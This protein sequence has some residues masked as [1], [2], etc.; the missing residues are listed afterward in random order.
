MQ[1]VFSRLL[2]SSENKIEARVSCCVLFKPTK[3]G[4]GSAAALM[5]LSLFSVKSLKA[6]KLKNTSPVLPCLTG[7]SLSS[8]EINKHKVAEM[9]M[10]KGKSRIPRRKTLAD[11]SNMPQGF[12]ASYQFHKSGPS[13]DALRKHLKQLQKKMQHL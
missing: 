2:C 6:L 4:G 3:K 9:S 5:S 10:R 13:S 11:I 7:D 8:S 1:L 12:T